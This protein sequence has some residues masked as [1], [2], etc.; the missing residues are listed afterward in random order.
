MKHEDAGKVNER[1]RHERKPL[2]TKI[3]FTILLPYCAVGSTKDISDGG[4]CFVV[5]KELNKGFILRLEMEL[6]EGKVNQLAKV[7][8]QRKAGD[9]FLTGVK[10]LT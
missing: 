7:M 9:K 8:W 2:E 5:D 4:M 1:R 10:F 6:S 3:K